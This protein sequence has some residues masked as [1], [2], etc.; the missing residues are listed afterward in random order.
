MARIASSGETGGSYAAVLAVQLQYNSIK[1]PSGKHGMSTSDNPWMSI[2]HRMPWLPMSYPCCLFSQI[3]L[4]NQTLY[5]YFLTGMCFRFTPHFYFAL[6]L[7]LFT[8]FLIPGR[9]TSPSAG[10]HVRVQS[11]GANC[12]DAYQVSRREADGLR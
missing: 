10:R 8:T 2:L 5:R 3:G 11:G 7:G 1:H 9:L 12:K 4:L 6:F